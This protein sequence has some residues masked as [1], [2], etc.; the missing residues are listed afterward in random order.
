[1]TATSSKTSSANTSPSGYSANGAGQQQVGARWVLGFILGAMT[2]GMIGFVGLIIGLVALGDPAPETI[3]STIDVSTR[4]YS[5]TGNL[6]VPAGD[7]TLRIANEG[8]LEHNVGIK[9]LGTVSPNVGP[10]GTVELA[11]GELEPGVYQMFCDIDGHESSGMVNTLT[12]TGDGV[13]ADAAAAAGGG[14]GEM[15]FAAMDRAM[16]ESM[17]A[18]PAETEGKGNPILEPTE[19]LSDGTKVF[20]LTAEIVEWEIEPGRLVEAWTYN[21]VVPAPQILLDRGDKVQVRVVNNLPLGTDIHWHGVHTPNDQDGVA[22][23]TQDLIEPN[24]GTFTYEFV[25]DEDAIGMY[26]AHNHA[27]MQ[28]VNGMFGVFRVGEN[29]IPYGQTISG[30]TIPDEIDLA[31]DMPMILNDA[32]TIGLSLNGKSFPGHRAARARPGRLGQRHVLQRGAADPPDAPPPVPAAGVRQG[33]HPARSAVLGRHART[34]PPVSA[35]PCCSRRSMPAPGSGT[36]TSSATS[37]G[38]RACSAW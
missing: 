37:S 24:G 4:E 3:S 11:L 16:T 5:I 26:H 21:G 17:L 9:E 20:D 30:V 19:I 32:G 38:T 31:V 8:S 10:G 1:M 7:V 15:D 13:T 14:Q 25:V 34:W 33:R 23:Y 29:P 22:P 2:I 6:T 27:Q 28:V 35:T 18:F 36:A 12:V